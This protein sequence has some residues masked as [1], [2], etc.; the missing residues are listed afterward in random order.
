METLP[1]GTTYMV[2]AILVTCTHR[3]YR[4]HTKASQGGTHCCLPVHKEVPQG[5][6][7]SLEAEPAPAKLAATNKEVKQWS[8][9]NVP[10][11]GAVGDVCTTCVS[12]PLFSCCDV[13]VSI[14]ATAWC[15]HIPQVSDTP[16]PV[17]TVPSQSSTQTTSV[18]CDFFFLTVTRQAQHAVVV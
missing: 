5:K 13:G 9:S 18:G 11:G 2:R 7:G 10:T 1:R 14:A 4:T 6:L 17:C 15:S 3:R 8:G 12:V 16:P